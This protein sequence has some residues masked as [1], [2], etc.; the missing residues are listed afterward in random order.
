MKMI[1]S[2]NVAHNAVQTPMGVGFSPRLPLTFYW[3]A[4]GVAITSA[5]EEYQAAL[6]SRVLKFGEKTPEQ[7]VSELAPYVAHENAAWLRQEA[8][9]L[10]RCKAVLEH[11]GLADSDGQVTLTLEGPGGKSF[12]LKVKPGP[13][14]APPSRG[15]Q[16]F[17]W[18]KYMEESATLYIQYNVCRSDPKL[19][20]N[21]FT[22]KVL[23]DADAHQVRRVIID[24][25]GNSGGNSEVINPLRNG[26]LARKRKLGRF[27]VL[28]GASTFSSGLL[29]AEQLHTQLH[30]TLVG[31]P[32]GERPGSYGEVKVVTLPNTQLKVRYTV[33]YFGSKNDTREALTPDV[34]VPLKLTD[35]LAGRDAALEAAI[36]G[37]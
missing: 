12:P 37:R 24:L 27:Y 10:L 23:A 5:S 15:Q 26:L 32:T 29:N 4:D 34:L 9:S 30:A 1:A 31:E 7:V 11:L 8:L 28:I 21:E 35:V 33:K 19:P 17:Y 2:A 36:A 16:G 3:Y 20:F 14:N 22:A 13:M 25:R 6:H 18:H